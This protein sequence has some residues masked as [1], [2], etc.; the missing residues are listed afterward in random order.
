MDKHM[1]KMKELGIEF[2][3]AEESE[4]SRFIMIPKQFYNCPFYKHFLTATTR[5][6]YAWL[7]DRMSLSERTTKEGNKSFVDENGYIYLVF[8]RAE[9]M[10]TLNISKQTCSNAF[11]ILNDLGLIYEKRQ[12]QG[13]TNLIYIGKLKYMNEKEATHMIK[14]VEKQVIIS[15]S[16]KSKNYT[17]KK[18]KNHTSRSLEIKLLEVQKLD[19]N[20]TNNTNTDNTNTDTSSS[21]GLKDIYKT[22]EENICSLKKTTMLKFKTLIEKY[23]IAFLKAIIEECT[24]T[25]VKS[26]K[27]FEVALQ[28]YVDAKCTTSEEV[29]QYAK[30]YSAKKKK[31][32]KSLKKVKELDK[33]TGKKLGFKNFDER[34]YDYDKLEKQLL[35]W[36]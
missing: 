17:S 7:V 1:K 13:K 3:R 14:L 6:L 15:Q 22:F 23:D 29:H 32:F 8:T 24:Y 9:I 16:E 27:G 4:S 33:I 10:E 12:G 35:G 31:S 2:Y 36:E 25:N 28:N 20:Y 5:E 21:K 18:S 34:E 30:D 11:K 26:Y 19:G